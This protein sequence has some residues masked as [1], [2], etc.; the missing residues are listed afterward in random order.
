MLHAYEINQTFCSFGYSSSIYAFINC[1]ISSN[2]FSLYFSKTSCGNTKSCVIVILTTILHK[3]VSAE[4]FNRYFKPEIV[5]TIRSFLFFVF[6]I[7]F[8]LLINFNCFNVLPSLFSKILRPYEAFQP[9][10]Y[11]LGIP[12][13]RRVTFYLFF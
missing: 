2:F 3:N 10:N 4:T 13:L 11:T 6:C 5:E 8:D 9:Y 7:S 1:F 12:T